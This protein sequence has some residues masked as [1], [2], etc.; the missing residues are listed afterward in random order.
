[1]QHPITGGGPRAGSAAKSNPATFTDRVSSMAGRLSLLNQRLEEVLAR[2]RG[3]RPTAVG[4][5]PNCE[6]PTLYSA[7]SALEGQISDIDERVRE[8]AETF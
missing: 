6:V 4:P 7:C 3:S 5:D 8:L 2:V 1:M